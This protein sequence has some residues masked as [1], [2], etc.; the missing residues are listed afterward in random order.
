MVSSGLKLLMMFYSFNVTTSHFISHIQPAEL[1]L[2]DIQGRFYDLSQN[3]S[4]RGKVFQALTNSCT[5]VMGQQVQ[6]QS[7][8]TTNEK[9]SFECNNWPVQAFQEIPALR[10]LSIPKKS[11]GTWTRCYIDSRENQATLSLRFESSTIVV[12]EQVRQQLFSPQLSKRSLVSSRN[13]FSPQTKRRNVENLLLSPLL[14]KK[15]LERKTLFSPQI[16]KKSKIPL[17]VRLP[18]LQ[19]LSG[20]VLEKSIQRLFSPTIPTN[21]IDSPRHR[22]HSKQYQQNM[23]DIRWAGRGNVVGP[24]FFTRVHRSIDLYYKN[25]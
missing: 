11:R 12:S 25:I 20:S 15:D 6:S 14:K 22:Y 19:D 16:P 8:Y 10:H 13:L 9:G 21:M 2:W 24:P 4:L 3:P 17:T 23:Y 5:S 18:E 7:T 1:F